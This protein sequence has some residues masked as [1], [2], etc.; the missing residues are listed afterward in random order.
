MRIGL[1]YGDILLCSEGEDEPV[2][3]VIGTYSI[4]PPDAR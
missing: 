4:P 3:H 2:A 1:A